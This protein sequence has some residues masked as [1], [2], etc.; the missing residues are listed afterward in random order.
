MDRT[1][2]A[3]KAS[4]KQWNSI[5]KSLIE[6]GKVNCTY[7]CMLQ[8]SKY[9]ENGRMPWPLVLYIIYRLYKDAIHE[10]QIKAN[11]FLHDSSPIHVNY[12]MSNNVC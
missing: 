12:N 3:I 4:V 5:R 10:K 2:L 7:I 8:V 1:K 11:K 6:G 9:Y